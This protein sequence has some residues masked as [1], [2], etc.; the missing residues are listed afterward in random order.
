VGGILDMFAA[1]FDI[2]TGTG[3]SVAGSG[4][5]PKAEDSKRNQGLQFEFHSRSFLLLKDTGII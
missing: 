3:D 4:K 5:N 2:L 1:T